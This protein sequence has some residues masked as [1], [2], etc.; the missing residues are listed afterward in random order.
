MPTIPPS[1]VGIYN[2]TD[3]GDNAHTEILEHT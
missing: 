3:M 1:G 2:L